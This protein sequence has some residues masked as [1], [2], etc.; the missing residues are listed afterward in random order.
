M[1]AVLRRTPIALVCAASLVAACSRRDR[2]DD[3]DKVA[4][5]AQAAAS[6][7]ATVTPAAPALTDANIFA[8]LDEANAADSAAGSVAATKGTNPAVKSFGREMMRDHH[9][10]RAAGLALAKKL[11]VTPEMPAGDTSATAATKWHDSLTAMP[12]GASWDK[13]YIDHEV[14]YHEAVLATAQAAAAAAQNAEL[15]TFIQKAEPNIQAHLAHAKQIQ[16]TL[17]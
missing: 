12:R 1:L 7:A 3:R 11:N 8:L 15:K 6:P 5:T 16:S 13:A 4:D 14:T 2:D 10:L 9:A 17:K